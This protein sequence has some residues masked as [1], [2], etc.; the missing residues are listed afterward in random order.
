MQSGSGV[1]N[2]LAELVRTRTL[3]LLR[4]RA[5]RTNLRHMVDRWILRKVD[6]FALE[7]IIVIEG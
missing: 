1:S 7:M 2:E 6:F 3:R 5:D 4:G